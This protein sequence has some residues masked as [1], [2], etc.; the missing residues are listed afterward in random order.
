MKGKSRHWGC[1]KKILKQSSKEW[2][3]NLNYCFPLWFSVTLCS[4]STKE[5][6]GALA[7]HPQLLCCCRNDV[8][9]CFVNNTPSTFGLSFTQNIFFST[10]HLGTQKKWKQIQPYTWRHLSHSNP[11]IG[12]QFMCMFL[13]CIQKYLGNLDNLWIWL[14]HSILVHSGC[15][16]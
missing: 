8:C 15:I 13:I 9:F 16:P 4:Q 2:E 14:K 1:L 3:I 6:S 10:Y 5:K 12:A 11:L 7:L